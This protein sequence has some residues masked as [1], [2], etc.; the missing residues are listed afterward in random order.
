MRTPI[1]NLHPQPPILAPFAPSQPTQTHPSSGYLSECLKNYRVICLSFFAKPIES[2]NYIFR[3][4]Q[5]L[6]EAVLN[7]VA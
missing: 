5:H 2:Q 4:S 6:W 7:V 3:I 1:I